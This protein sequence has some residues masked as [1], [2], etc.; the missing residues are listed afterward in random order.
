M[1]ALI[2][3]SMQGSRLSQQ[4]QVVILRQSAEFLGIQLTGSQLFANPADRTPVG[5]VARSA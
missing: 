5:N 1:I 2:F 3:A 4:K